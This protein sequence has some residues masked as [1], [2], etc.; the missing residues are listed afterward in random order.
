MLNKLLCGLEVTAPIPQSYSLSDTEKEECR[1]LLQVIVDRWT[2]LKTTSVETLRETF[3]R[4]EGILTKEDKGWVLKVERN[5]I[6]MLMD[7]LPWAISIVS[8]PWNR[9]IIYTEW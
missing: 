2:V 9:E 4:K 1:N 3:L 8:L 7:K 6:D 5:T